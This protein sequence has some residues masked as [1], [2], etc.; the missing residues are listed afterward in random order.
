MPNVS[1]STRR[2]EDTMDALTMLEEQHEALDAMFEEYEDADGKD[3]KQE[4]FTQIADALAIHAAIEEKH[5][6]PA[7]K[8]QR[9]EDILLE[10][11]EEHLAAKRLIADLLQMSPEDETF[12]AKMKVLKEEIQ[13]H[14]KEEEQELFPKVKRILS[15]EQLD[16]IGSKME[17]MMEELEQG[18]PR[19]AVLGQTRSAATL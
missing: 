19:R 16:T 1:P 4:L 8:E 5:F 6:Y 18:E 12:D 14:V 15:E 9:T 17:Q 11:L 3:E 13:H 2:K 10:A 7:V